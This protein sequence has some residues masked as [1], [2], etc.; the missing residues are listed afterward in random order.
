MFEPAAGSADL[1]ATPY[2]HP[3][4]VGAFA[5]AVGYTERSVETMAERPRGRAAPPA[6]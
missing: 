6:R 5:L 1:E 3:G 4:L 2:D